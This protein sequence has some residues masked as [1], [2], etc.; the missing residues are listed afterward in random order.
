MFSTVCTVAVLLTVVSGCPQRHNDLL[1]WE[2]P[3]NEDCLYLNVFTPKPPES[4]EPMPVMVWI[5]GGAYYSGSGNLYDGTALAKQ[6]V[7]FV[8]IN[9]RLDALG[10]LSTQDGNS[11]G[12]Y[13]L[14]DQIRAL[15][16]VRDSI[17]AFNGDPSNVTICGES[18]G[19]TSVSLLVMSRA[20]KGLFQRAIMQSGSGLSSWA[21]GYP[22]L[23]PRPLDVAQTLA[24]R[25][26][27]PTDDNSRMVDCLR[28]KD[29]EVI[30]N[31]TTAMSESAGV[32]EF[33]PVP[34]TTFGQYG[35][36]VAAPEA[37]MENGWFSNVS[38]IRGFNTEESATLDLDPEN[39][40][41]TL[42]EFKAKLQT[43]TSQ[44]FAQSSP[45]VTV[46]TDTIQALIL[47]AYVTQPGITKPDDLRKAFIQLETDYFFVAPALQEL[48][49]MTKFP[50]MPQYLY[51]FSHR[52]ANKLGP[53]WTDEPSFLDI[54]EPLRF[55]P[56]ESLSDARYTLWT[57][58]IPKL[59]RGQNL[60]G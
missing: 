2:F 22:R 34:E 11:P 3:N 43:L 26:N 49:L 50:V 48:K 54:N 1:P 20:A 14:L 29:V 37:I 57:D 16:W 47:D 4:G 28:D 38:T 21:M 35:I 10:F 12:N 45:A 33:K 60:I 24:R 18:A 32:I 56:F 36:F 13:G 42:T 27:C 52:S 9:Y 39:D 58:A 51:R 55:R 40:G 25:V 8:A 6:G 19:S 23:D 7:V 44:Y 41:M 15:E 59:L 46:D 17:S 31:A 53:K 30:I 5:H